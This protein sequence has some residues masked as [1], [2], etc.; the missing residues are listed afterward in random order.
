M[1]FVD[2]S[3]NSANS[4]RGK[5]SFNPAALLSPPVHYRDKRIRYE[6]R[7]EA[8]YATGPLSHFIFPS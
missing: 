8:D 4:D 1:S 5:Q 2:S 7:R 6:S 3:E